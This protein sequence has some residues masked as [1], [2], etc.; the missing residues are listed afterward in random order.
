N[1]FFYE[2]NKDKDRGIASVTDSALAVNRPIAITRSKMFR[3]LFSA[4]PSICIN[5]STLKQ[6]IQNGIE[7]LRSYKKEWCED[8]LIWDYERIIDKVIATSPRYS[9]RGVFDPV[10]RPLFSVLRHFKRSPALKDADSW[11]PQIHR[12]NLQSSASERKTYSF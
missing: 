8:N 12:S 6:I 3:H 2:E 10:V 9:L 4:T 11:I 5:D 7:P 1:A